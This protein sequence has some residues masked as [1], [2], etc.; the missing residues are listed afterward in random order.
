VATLAASVAVRQRGPAA[1]RLEVSGPLGSVQQAVASVDVRDVR[2][3]ARRVGLPVRAEWTGRW[4]VDEGG[5]HRVVADS[6]GRLAVEVDG[7]VIAQASR[8]RERAEIG[9]HQGLHRVALR[10][11]TAAPP[12][13]FTV[14]FA[15]AE[16][17]R[18][19]FDADAV[20][21]DV[22]TPGQVRAA[23]HAPVLRASAL[24]AWLL[25]G[26]GA[27]VAAW[28]RPAWRGRLRL[29]LLA[30]VVAYGGALRFE[31]LVARYWHD[32]PP[33]ALRVERVVS[34]IAPGEG[35]FEPSLTH[36]GGDPYHYYLRA[37]EMGGFYEPHVREPLFPATARLLIPLLGDRPLVVDAASALFSTLAVLGT[38]AL[39]TAASGPWVGLAAAVVVAIDPDVVWWGVEGFRDDA[40]MAFMLLATASLLR[41]REEPTTRWGVLAGLAAAATLLSRVTGLSFLGPAFGALALRGGAAGRARRRALAV[42]AGVAALV[43]GPYLLACALAFGDP[44]HAVNHHTRF[45]RSRSG[46][47]YASDMSWSAWLTRG[48]AARDLVATGASG[49]TTYPFRNKFRGLD[50]VSPRVRRVLAPAAVLGLAL[51]VLTARG[52]L[53]LLVLFT[54][55][56]PYAFTWKVPGGSEFRFTMHAY[57]FY[58]AAAFAALPEARATLARYRARRLAAPAVDPGPPPP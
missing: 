42:A 28:Q 36:G 35:H 54:S 57:A 40:F 46:Q 33:W 48:F 24:V 6:D 21:A 14:H 43:A 17:G 26:L 55:L 4:R 52:R 58:L 41:L 47:A 31:A 51:F 38:A 49:L 50:T 56:L 23:R 25:V 10:Y 11:E 45:Y 44:F 30:A 34:A 5:R 39:G 22:P 32:A 15:H 53:V 12:G 37:R 2:D 7:Q 13:R 20:S 8:G 3:L 27:L 18:R 29:V 19:A 9:L 1:L 16:G